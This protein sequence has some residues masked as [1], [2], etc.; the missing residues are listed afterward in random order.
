M[1]S[2]ISFGLL[3]PVAAAWFAA[4]VLG[5][6]GA[7]ES[8]PDRAAKPD[9]GRKA[10]RA[11]D[12]SGVRSSGMF[13]EPTASAPKSPRTPPPSSLDA[14]R[15]KPTKTPSKKPRRYSLAELLSG[16]PE[17]LA[18]TPDYL[19][20]PPDGAGRWL[21]DWPRMEI[22]DARVAAE[23][24]RKLQGKHLIL[25]TDLDSEPEVDELPAVFDRAFPQWCEYLGVD[26][27]EHDDWSLTGIL[28]RDKQRFRRAGLM[29]D[30]L[31]PFPHGY[32]RNFEFWLYEQPSAYYRRHL[33]LHE[34]T[35]GFMNTLLGS[36][37]PPWYM[38][39]IAE[40]LATHRWRDGRLTLNVFPADRDEVPMWGRVKIV[41]EAYAERR[42]RHL[43]DVIEYSR[44][45]H[46]QN[47]PYGW[48]W[49]A[50]AFLD[51]HP[52]YRE[53]FR[54]LPEL[55]RYADFS[56]RFDTMMAA[57]WDP[58]C[59]EWELFVADLEYGYDTVRNAID[60]Q[61]GAPLPRGGA[62]ATV[63]A[64]RGWQSSRLFLEAGK[65]YRLAAAGRYQVADHPQIWWCEP[66]GV[67]IRY[68]DGQPLGILLAA[69]R[70]EKYDPPTPSALV[71]ALV[72]G[73]K[74]EIRP[75]ES[76]T[77]YFRINDSPA[78]LADNAGILTVRVEEAGR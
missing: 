54:E 58:L 36:C 68:W 33:L 31:P 18:Q 57:D 14:K 12:S 5:C 63:A 35:H 60:F 47:E 78:E 49:A 74:A 9:S 46:R 48:C 24:I 69:V 23:G 7:A 66:G 62:S 53:R 27:K 1:D 52:R 11:S 45:A 65:T 72:V 15:T 37:G 16:D 20:D 17:A 29:P 39:G 6:G 44:T 41:K 61:P 71:R 30:D 56:R 76:G 26:A 73:L 64:D 59:E 4:A 32:A 22:D 8:P 55:V 50:A 70:P 25:Y 3:R 38:E 21:P 77:L 19:I 13:R 67:T 10:S 51:G 42:G 75:T 34:G 28:M 43:R 2:R 40:L